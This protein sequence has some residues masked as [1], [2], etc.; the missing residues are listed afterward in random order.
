[1]KFNLFAI[2]FFIP[3]L[4]KGQPD[5]I[6]IESESFTN[7]GGW[8]VDQQ[9][10]D[11]MGSPF[12]MAHGLGK[13]VADATTIINFSKKA[14][15]HVFVRTR[16]WVGYWSDKDA[17]GKFKLLV[18]D[19]PLNVTFGIQDTEWNWQSGGAIKIEKGKAKIS[20]HDL[21]GFNGRCDAILF[22]TD[23]SF[24]PGNTLDELASFRKK[25]LGLPD[26]PELAGKFDFVVVGGGVAGTCA[27]ISASRL[28]LKVALIQDRPVL[29][30][31]NSSEVRVHLGG[32]INL[33]PYPALG[34]IVNEIGPLKAGN[35][36]PASNYEDQKKLDVVLAKK[37]SLFFS[38]IMQTG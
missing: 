4:V 25:A 13:P 18:N 1:M 11:Q 37:T 26:K 30:G 27:A 10:M 36:Q 15:Y 23:P 17:P 20:L 5:N 33:L 34:N 21:S 32:R 14:T 7:K 2:V 19:K 9:F 35:A 38:T 16:N 8:V 28:G 29:G 12:L 3:F 22:T 24:R 6:L 31:N